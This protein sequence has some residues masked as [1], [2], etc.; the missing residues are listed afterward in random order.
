MF[1]CAQS[2]SDLSGHLFDFATDEILHNVYARCILE[3]ASIS[4]RSFDVILR[5]IFLKRYVPGSVNPLLDIYVTSDNISIFSIPRN[6]LSC[7]FTNWFPSRASTCRLFRLINEIATSAIYFV[8]VWNHAHAHLMPGYRPFTGLASTYTV[9]SA[10][11]NPNHRPWELSGRGYSLRDFYFLNTFNTGV[12]NPT[13]R[14]LA[15]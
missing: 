10:P 4:G 6:T 12:L 3:V 15:T 14:G 11:Y 5:R 2:N 13:Q 9:S 1:F 8:E 7:K